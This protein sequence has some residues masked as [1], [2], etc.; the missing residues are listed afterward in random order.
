MFRKLVAELVARAM[1]TAHP[2]KVAWVIVLATVVLTADVT[3]AATQV[4]VAVVAAWL[5]AAANA[6]VV[7]AVGAIADLLA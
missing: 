1:T 3:A 4:N 6:G 2:S 5:I 7:F